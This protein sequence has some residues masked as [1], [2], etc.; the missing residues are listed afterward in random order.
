MILDKPTEEALKL[1]SEIIAMNAPRK[2]PLEGAREI[3][4]DNAELKFGSDLIEDALSKHL[5]VETHELCVLARP[6][7]PDRLTRLLEGPLAS[8]GFRVRA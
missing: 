8:L 7:D 5:D 6:Q 4:R 1:C 2:G 3:F